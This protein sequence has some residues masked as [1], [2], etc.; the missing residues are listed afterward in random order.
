MECSIC[1][2]TLKSTDKQFTTPC[3][4]T[5][6]WKCFYE[7]ALKSRGTLFVPCPLCRQINNRFPDF[8]S[9]KENLLSLITHPR[10][11]CCAKTKRGTR[12]QKKAHPFN[13][14]MCRIHSP[15]ILPEERYPLYHDY[16]KYMLDCTNTWRTKVYMM[17]IAKQLLI[18]RP[19]IQKIT[20]FHHLFL[21]FFHICRMNGTVDPNSC[22]IGHPKDMYEFLNID[23]PKL[24]W[25]QDMCNYKI[26]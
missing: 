20:D 8:G 12:C 25:I 17:D 18:S 15:E 6:H 2:N 4:H 3:N 19:E 24:Q 5:F 16:L 1:L 10:E 23:P 26:Q 14:G 21:E 7:Y 9:E 13:R 11:R 22:I